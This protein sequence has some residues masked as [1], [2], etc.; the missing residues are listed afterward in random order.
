M[1]APAFD[2]DLAIIG[3]GGGASGGIVSSPRANA[4]P[5]AKLAS[6]LASG[7]SAS[8]QARAASNRVTGLGYR[9]SDEIAGLV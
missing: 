3:S 9:N 8:R 7:V 4:L 6:T 5:A 2:Y 1:S